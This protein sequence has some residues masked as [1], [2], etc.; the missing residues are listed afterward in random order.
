MT[1]T[2]IR[3]SIHIAAS[4]ETVW[5][6]LTQADLLG[7]WFHPAEA[8]LRDDTDYTLLS[9][10]D[11]DRMCW[12]KVVEMRRPE[13]MRWDFTVGPMQGAMS[14]VEWTLEE[15]P[16]GTRLTLEHSGLPQS[17]DG[18]GLVLALDKGW[19]G[20][21]ANLQ[22]LAA[23]DQAGD[24]FATIR[25]PAAPEAARRAIFDEM[26]TWWSSGVERSDTGVR[27]HFGPSHVDFDFRGGARPG[28]YDWL[29]TEAHMLIEGVQDAG[30]W[31][32]SHLLW[33]I[34]PEGSGSRITLT[35]KGLNPQMAC[36]DVCTRGWQ[37]YFEHSLREHLSGGIPTPEQR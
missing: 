14:T 12:G 11:G 9:Q 30:E 3:K 32:G 33:H 17:K 35:H 23:A 28:E 29:C 1:D 20:F 34:A 6:Y 18:F 16:D 13:Y 26:G 7:R 19:H 15:A 22:S 5:D 2:E 37:K 24:Y 8:D 4:R 27:V 25:V 36:A 31:Q 10:N 21:L